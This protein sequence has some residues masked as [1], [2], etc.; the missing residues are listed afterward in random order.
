M[1]AKFH[2]DWKI[3]NLFRDPQRVATGL[4]WKPQGMSMMQAV[5]RAADAE[6]TSM[7][8]MQAGDS[9]INVGGGF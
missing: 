2:L 9:Q 7:Q 8:Q 5:L 1:L 4:F 3:Q 6:H